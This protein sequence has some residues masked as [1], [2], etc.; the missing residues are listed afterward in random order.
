MGGKDILLK[1]PRDKKQE[2][3]KETNEKIQETKNKKQ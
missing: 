1:E 2:T 3:I